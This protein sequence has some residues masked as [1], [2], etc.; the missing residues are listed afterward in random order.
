M[1][2][3]LGTLLKSHVF[4]FVLLLVF[5]GCATFEVSHLLLEVLMFQV[6]VLESGSE[7]TLTSPNLAS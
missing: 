1:I 5:I 3:L 4:G 6:A 7:G 2:N